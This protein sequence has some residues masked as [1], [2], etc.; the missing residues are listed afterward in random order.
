MIDRPALASPARSL[1]S[2]A[3]S[4]RAAAAESLAAMP[5][6]AQVA[7]VCEAPLSRRGELLELLPE[8]EAVIPR[9]PEA[10][11]CFTVKAI[12]L[13][14]APWV[15]EHATPA[16]I[17]TCVDLDAWRGTV[18]DRG[19]LDTWMDALA[20]T[21]NGAFL[22]G[23]GALDPEVLV[24]YLK[25]RVDVVLKPNDDD[26]QPPDGAQTLEGQFYYSAHSP[27][28]DL[29]AITRLLRLL[30]END[31]W[32]YFRLM[33]GAIWELDSENE[34]WAL[35]W[36]SGRLEDL[37]FP[38][39]EEAMAIYATL[40]PGRL[41]AIPKEARPLD[42]REWRLPVWLPRLPAEPDSEYLVF[43]TIAQ[44][45]EHER[46]AALYA[47]IATANKVAVADRMPLG[48]AESTPR[49]IEKAARW[50][51]TGLAYVASENGI[52]AAEVLRSTP[53]QRLFQVG[54]NLDPQRARP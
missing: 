49:A 23:V 5:V 14:D 8:P 29:A 25:G 41:A 31:Y 2:L 54:A 35:R 53:L 32:T 48:E 20:E 52:E 30:F 38:P 24:L 39:W 47:F 22:R 15:L 19:A 21:G 40:R 46:R 44:L 51:S 6:E 4:D 37:G 43:R 12:G 50:I 3:R 17:A 26:W 9:I 10:E 34:E 27:K 11:L 16:Q 36:R 28:D 18:P 1:L 33:Q 45:D 7:L 13:E 42:V